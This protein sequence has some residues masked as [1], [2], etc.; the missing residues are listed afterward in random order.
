MNKDVEEAKARVTEAQISLICAVR[1]A[2]PKG[3]EVLAKLGSARVRIRVN[4][5]HSVPGQRAGLIFG[6]NLETGK[7][8]EF[9]DSNVLEIYPKED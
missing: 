5:H 6:I 3:T 2:Y 1:E 8:R 7:S 4:G 9:R